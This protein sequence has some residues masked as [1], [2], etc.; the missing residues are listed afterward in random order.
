L[1]SETSVAV[2]ERLARENVPFCFVTA[3]GDGVR[4][5]PAIPECPIVS[6]P[7]RIEEVTRVAAALLKL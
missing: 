4:D 7:Y 5:N 1:K 2:A 3:D 6:K